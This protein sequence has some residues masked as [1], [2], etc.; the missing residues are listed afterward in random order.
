MSPRQ[1]A[2]EEA[3]RWCRQHGVEVEWLRHD[4]VLCRLRLVH[5]SSART[6]TIIAPSF[7]EAYQVLRGELARAAPPAS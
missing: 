4:R 1:T 2:A 5:P 6:I 3:L 7:V